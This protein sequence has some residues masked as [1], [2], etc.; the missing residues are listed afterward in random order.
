MPRTNAYGELMSPLKYDHRI[1]YLSIPVLAKL[2]MKTKHISPYFV[3][4]PRFDFL[5]DYK[6][7]TLKLLY[8]E[9]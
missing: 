4:G 6:S 5:L 8:D 3:V 9:L 1:D 7:K 2:S